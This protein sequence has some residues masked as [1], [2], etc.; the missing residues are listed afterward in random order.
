MQMAARIRLSAV[1]LLLAWTAGAA[2][3]QPAQHRLIQDFLDPLRAASC[4]QDA[5]PR[6]PD[7]IDLHV[8]RVPLQAIN[9]VR[10]TIGELTF[11]GGFHLTSKDKRFGGLSGLDLLDDGRLLAVSDAGD[12]VWIALDGDGTTP[13]SASVAGMRGADGRSIRG[14]TQGDAEGLAIMDGMALVS[15][16]GDNRVLAFDLARCGPEARGAPVAESRVLSTAFEHEGLKVG[17]NGGLE[18][19]ALAPGGFLL[20]GIETR[21][22]DASAVSARS[23]GAAPA[24]DIRIGEGA[25]SLVGMDI[26]PDADD[27]GGFTLYSLHRSTSAMAREVIVLLET[28]FE[29]DFDQ[30][31]L[32]ARIVSDANER[33]RIGFRPIASRKLAAMNLLVTIDNFE[34]IAARQMPDGRVRLY[35]VSDD[36]FSASQRTLLMV[37]DVA[38]PG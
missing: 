10:K 24:F 30:S 36:N 3:A 1:A 12:F 18:A 17:G 8:T 9:P 25:P 35:V 2:E 38:K 20:A 13:V 15:F 16:E 19:L 32:P 21:A 23:L 28:E 29:R 22:G 6:E 31:N 34:G 27:D 4:P 33:S 5:E 14:K 11:V 26:L 7:A 37:Y